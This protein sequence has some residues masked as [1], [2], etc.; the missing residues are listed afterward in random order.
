MQLPA[1]D[2]VTNDGTILRT[3]SFTR[4][5]VV[6]VTYSFACPHSLA[7]RGRL[8]RLARDFE[9]DAQVLLVVC[10]DPARFPVDHA[11]DRTVPPPRIELGRDDSEVFTRLLGARVTPEAFVFDAE[12]TL[13]YRGRIDDEPF[14]ESEVHEPY[15]TRA[16]EAAIV[17]TKAPESS[18]AV[19]SPIAFR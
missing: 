6:V 7:Y 9:A 18:L 16:V 14:H 8:A 15:L 2:L 12:R 13:V 1:C 17:G 5:V 3:G 19:G 4:R 10:S 11:I